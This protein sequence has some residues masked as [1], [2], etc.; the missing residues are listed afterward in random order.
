MDIS[1]RNLFKAIWS[2]IY[3]HIFTYIFIATLLQLAMLAGLWFVGRVFQFSLSLAGE[4]NLDKNNIA[5]ILGNPY[6][7]II[8]LLLILIVAFLMFIEFSTLTFTIYGQLTENSYSLRTI[9]SNAW[10]KM[11][12]LVGFQILF[13]I[14][15]FIL[16]I[17]AANFGVK[18]IVTKNLYIPKFVTGEIIKTNTGFI[19]WSLVVVLFA[20]INLRLIFTL[21]LTAVGDTKIGASIKT[22]WKFTQKGKFKFLLTLGLFELIYSVIVITIILATT[23]IFLYIDP[24][25]NNLIIQTLFFTIVSSIIFFFG[26]IS[27]ITVITALI[28]VLIDK[29]IIFEKILNSPVKNKKKAKRS[30]ALSLALVLSITLYNG[31]IIYTNGINKDIKTIS[32]RGYTSK[33]VENSIESLEAA[34]NAG[35]DYV[36]V[37]ILL[38]KDN[39]FIVMHD[40]NLKR[41]A[42]INRRVQDMNYNEV[43]GLP[44]KQGGHRSKIPSFEEFVTRAKQLNIKLLIELKPHGGEP[45][46]YIEIF[47]NKIKELGIEKEYKYMSLNLKIIE[48]LETKFPELNTGYVIPLQL[49]KFSNNKV[50]FYVIEDFSYRDSLVEQART[51]NKEVYVWTINDL[52]LIRRYLQSPAAAI[53]TDE[54]EVVKE[55]KQELQNNNTY[56]D[57][58]IRLIDT[59]N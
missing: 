2:N 8:L 33:G 53:I 18:S 55:E 25:G 44:I 47:I 19:I 36:E 49:G 3:K 26:I 14:G 48:E 37:D 12:S 32:H 20:Y 21:P 4:T 1:I 56:L 29:K 51:Q 13:F 27:K 6:S 38:T 7:L 35:V 42:G 50:D 58:V 10:E 24:T 23:A 17:P 11:R 52:T 5:G 40:Y 59:K 15:Y 22:S 30:L 41:L 46:N 43:V 28:T 9:I 45:S 16:T 39:K 54:P 34:A 31:S 57:R